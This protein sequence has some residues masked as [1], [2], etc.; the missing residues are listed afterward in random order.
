MKWKD[1]TIPGYIWDKNC[2]CVHTQKIERGKS[3]QYTAHLMTWME[4][5]SDVLSNWF[6]GNR[7]LANY[8]R[9]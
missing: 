1:V 2:E 5:L 9:G 7:M 6:L 4:N 8:A 3:D